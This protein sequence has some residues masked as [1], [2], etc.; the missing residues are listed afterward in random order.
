MP[1]ANACEGENERVCV[2][3]S[4]E[5]ANNTIAKKIRTYL[6]GTGSALVV[7]RLRLVVHVEVDAHAVWPHPG[8]RIHALAAELALEIG[9]EE[10]QSARRFG[11]DGPAAALLRHD[12]GLPAVRGS[13]LGV[14]LFVVRVALQ[15]RVQNVRVARGVHGVGDLLEV[16]RE[17][18]SLYTCKRGIGVN[19][20]V[21]VVKKRSANKT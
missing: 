9:V 13:K 15:Q 4:K 14:P 5:N 10:V 19:V 21:K 16:E 7:H 2:V 12:V 18:L 11:N 17:R 8:C 6:V 3:M 20:S 1:D